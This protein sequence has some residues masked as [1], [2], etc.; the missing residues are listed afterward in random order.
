MFHTPSR[1]SGELEPT[2]FGITFN[3]YIEAW[4]VNRNL[5]PIE[6]LNFTGVYVDAN[7]VVA[8][9]GQTSPGDEAHVAGAENR[10]AHISF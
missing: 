6:A 1:V 2:G 8:S 10:N 3:D 9:I 7:H 4:L 5:A